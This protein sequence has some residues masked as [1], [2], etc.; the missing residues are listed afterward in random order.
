MEEATRSCGERNTTCCNTRNFRE[1]QRAQLPVAVT[2]GQ[3]TLVSLQHLGV[4][5]ERL[6]C[7]LGDSQE[8]G[9]VA[10]AGQIGL[11][12]RSYDRVMQDTP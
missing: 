12:G 6:E 8:S 7:R 1:R 9:Q 10:A 4:G 11:V 3:F 5:V 2:G